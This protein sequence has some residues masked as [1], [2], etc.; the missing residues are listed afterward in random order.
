MI[1]TRTHS[2]ETLSKNKPRT[3]ISLSRLLALVIRR[4]V[5]AYL[6][7]FTR[8]SLSLFLLS[9]LV[10]LTFSIP[11]RAFASVQITELMYDPPGANAGNQWVEVTNEG[12]EPVNLFGYRLAEGGTNHK[13]S[14]LSGTT[15]LAAGESAIITN[16][17]DS[18]SSAYPGYLGPLFKSSFSLA[19]KTGETV[20]LKN[21]K[22]ETLDT[23]TYY[24]SAGA[25]GDGNTLHRSGDTLTV[26]A[27]NPGD[28]A[29]TSPIVASASSGGTSAKTASS[30]GTKATAKGKTTASSRT[31]NARY[32]NYEQG[33]QAASPLLSQIN[34]P[35]GPLAWALGGFG[36]LLLGISAL[37][38]M[39]LH[40]AQ[41]GRNP[42]RPEQFTIEE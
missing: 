21:A 7:R 29:A 25:A 40:F 32:A 9:V 33:T 38:Y 10:A 17:A 37:W 5:D 13:I 15:T 30:A 16:S 28:T 6:L 4:Y 20:I 39:R 31:S 35:Q 23:V 12:Q 3:A 41:Q 22:L 27:P 18:F 2:S 42:I 19:S 11:A 36:L 1:S 14:I 8:C 34:V 26:G 24:P